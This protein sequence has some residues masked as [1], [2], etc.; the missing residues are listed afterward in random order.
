MDRVIDG[1][2][3]LNLRTYLTRWMSRWPSY[4]WTEDRHQLERRLGVGGVILILVSLAAWL[5]LRYHSTWSLA[6]D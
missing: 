6:A 2:C 1:S 4:D 3:A 5:V